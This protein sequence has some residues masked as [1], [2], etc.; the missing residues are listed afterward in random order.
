MFE[1]LGEK[2]GGRRGGRMENRE[3]IDRLSSLMKLDYDAVLAYERAVASVKSGEVQDALRRIRQDHERHVRELGDAIRREGGE[4]PELSKAVHGVFLEGI[5][6]VTG[7]IG[8]RPV[9][10]ACETG[11]KYVNYKYRQAA[12]EEL[13]S[14]VMV[15]VEKNYADERRHLSYIERRL[16]VAAAGLGVGKTIGILALGV[17]A[18]AVIGRQIASR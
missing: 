11:E 16:A 3:I 5:A 7:A 4:P 2:V 1:E 17:A 18:G 8:E 12:G 9:L 6:A 10:S 14:R 15:M 13:P